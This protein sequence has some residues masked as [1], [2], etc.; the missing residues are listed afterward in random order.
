MVVRLYALRLQEQIQVRLDAR[1]SPVRVESNEHAVAVV[2]PD[3]IV[4]FSSHALEPLTTLS[5]CFVQ[6]P[7]RHNPTALGPRWLA[8]ATQQAVVR[9]EAAPPAS[10][11]RMAAAMSFAQ[12]TSSK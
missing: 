2:L 11:T 6:P 10:T 7:L 3:S 1:G 8:Y 9:P 5:D 12:K 4:L